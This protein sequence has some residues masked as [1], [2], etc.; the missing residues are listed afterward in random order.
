MEVMVARNSVAVRVGGVVIG[1][2]AP[3]VVQ[4][5]TSTDTADVETTVGQIVEL[6][7]AGSELV[8]VTVNVP[9]AAARRTTRTFPLWM[10]DEYPCPRSLTSPFR[11]V[12]TSVTVAVV[13]DVVKE[14]SVSGEPPT[15][16]MD[17]VWPSRSVPPIVTREPDGPAA[18]A[19]DQ[20]VDRLVGEVAKRAV[21]AAEAAE[22]APKLQL[23]E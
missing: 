9:E 20:I 1:G 22:A 6:A 12:A 14:G 21:A 17:Q 18:K 19:F 16:L 5:M 23:V 3:V 15:R 13:A 11:S 7:A 4:S 10:K 8:R 2:G